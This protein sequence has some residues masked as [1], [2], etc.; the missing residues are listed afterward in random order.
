M[1]AYGDG[2]LDPSET[3]VPSLD[4][5]EQHRRSLRSA[6]PKLHGARHESS[7]LEL[8]RVANWCEENNVTADVYGDGEHLHTFERRVAAML[9]YPAARFMPS[10]TMAQQIAARIWSDN[11]GIALIGLHPT[12]HLELHEERGYDRLHNLTAVMVGETHR[13]MSMSDLAAIS[14]ELAV[15]IV[16]LPTRENGG[17]LTPWEDLVALSALARERNITTHLDGARLWEAAAG[18]ERPLD[19]LCA[20][21][22]S[23]YVSFYKGI[24]AL[25]GSVLAGPETFIDEATLWQRRQGGNLFTS[26]AN[27]VSADM[28]LDSQIA[29]MP[30]YRARATELAEALGAID[31]ITITPPT[32]QV[33]MFHV[34]LQGE[35]EALL[36]ARDRVATTHALWLFGETA[37]TDTPHTRAFECTV[38]DAACALDLADIIAA[39][40]ELVRLAQQQNH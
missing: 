10:G 21:F 30:E 22:D 20:L 24:G 7:H 18:Y 39:F 3:N 38:G 11:R 37:A 9:G 27:W 14:D 5:L 26:M 34:S 28:R 15:L 19:E 13:P 8:V 40:N 35:Q 25:P 2:V 17:Q 36:H 31:G 16:E 1:G 12:S 33:N 6:T 23:T 29:K 32:P 4:D